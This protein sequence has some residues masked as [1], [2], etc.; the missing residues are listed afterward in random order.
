M[1]RNYVPV[2]GD[3]IFFDWG[4]DGS[5]DHAGIVVNVEGGM[6]HTVEGNSGSM[7]KKGSWSVGD[8]RIYGYGKGF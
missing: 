7:V 8:R 6:V 1:E 3:I 5:I 4:N 2:P